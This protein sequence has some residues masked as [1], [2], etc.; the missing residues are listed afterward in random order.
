MYTQYN[1]HPFINLATVN[2]LLAGM[3]VWQTHYLL[4]REANVRFRTNPL[5]DT[6]EMLV[7]TCFQDQE[8]HVKVVVGG[9]G[10]EI[11]VTKQC[12]ET[13]TRAVCNMFFPFGIAHGSERQGGG[14]EGTLNP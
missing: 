2:Y 6:W 4:G 8:P 10:Q 9:D 7:R 13:A 3:Q 14:H 11:W 12:L 1:Y 5:P